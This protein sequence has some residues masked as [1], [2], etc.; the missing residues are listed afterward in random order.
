MKTRSSFKYQFNQVI[1]RKGTNA[2]SLTGYR[3]YLFD[4]NEDLSSQ[5]E[6]ADFIPMWVADM[7]FRIAP[8]IIDAMKNRLEHP[9]L[10][11]SIVADPAYSLAFQQWCIE[12]YDWKFD[13]EHLVYA[14]GVVPALYDLIGYICKPDEKVLILTPSYA[15][16]KHGV[17]F[18]EVGLICSDLIFD[19]G[20]YRMDINDIKQKASDEKCVLGIFC[21][22]H[23][24]TGRVWSKNCLLYTSP[25]PRD[26]STSRMPSSA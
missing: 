21:N 24:P 9:L 15:F 6:E 11:Y 14:K 4:E 1:D 25:S 22:P 23:N 19:D 12:R 8:E 26:L 5:Y 20:E 13:I 16:F 18:N 10:G 17:D 7:E 2:M 3:S